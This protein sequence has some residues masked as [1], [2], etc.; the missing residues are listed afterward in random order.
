MIRGRDMAE[1]WD[2]SIG[3]LFNSS[4]VPKRNGYSM[5]PTVIRTTEVLCICMPPY[6]RNEKK[7][8]QKARVS[9]SRNP[10]DGIAR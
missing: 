8:E 6:Q 10:C 9:D 7:A 2:W 3:N 5:L 4:E 1:G